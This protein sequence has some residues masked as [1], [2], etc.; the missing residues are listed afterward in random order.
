MLFLRRR[1]VSHE[2]PALPSLTPTGQTTTA[3]VHGSTGLLLIPS[4]GSQAA[5]K[6]TSPH[7]RGDP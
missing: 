4:G 1:E 5:R 2:G 3:V 7:L 6:R